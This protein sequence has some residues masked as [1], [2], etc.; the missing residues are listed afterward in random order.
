MVPPSDPVA[1]RRH[2][3]LMIVLVVAVDAVAIAIYYAGHMDRVYG[4]GRDVFTGVWLVVV[5]AIVF[6]QLRRIR[7][8][9]FGGSRRRPPDSTNPPNPPSSPNPTDRSDR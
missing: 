9:R 4:R 6:V 3:G 7:Q 2:L 8:A 1:M 5:L